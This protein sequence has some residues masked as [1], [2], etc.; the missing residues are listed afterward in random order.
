MSKNDA[1]A[2]EALR[3][4]DGMAAMA[5]SVEESGNEVAM[6]AMVRDAA[7]ALEVLRSHHMDMGEP[8]TLAVLN[9]NGH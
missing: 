8:V 3:T 7:W 9:G 6:S 5:E 1:A 2:R 4:L